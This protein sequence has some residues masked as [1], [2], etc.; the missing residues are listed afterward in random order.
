MEMNLN[1][2][3]SNLTEEERKLILIKTKEDMNAILQKEER[4]AIK[5]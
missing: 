4:Y 1:D 3:L 5:E 2:R